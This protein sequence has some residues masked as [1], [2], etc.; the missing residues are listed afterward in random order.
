MLSIG[1]V[2]LRS[3]VLLAP[4]AGYCDLPFRLLCRE[5]GGIGLASTDLLNSRSILRGAPQAMRLAATCDED[6]PLCM[7]LYGNDTDP[8][9][10]A[11]AWAVDHGAR[12]IDINMGCPQDKVAK[13]NGGSLLLCDP[14]RTLVLADRIVDA[15]RGTGVPV[16]AKVRL[17]WCRQTM[18]APELARGLEQIG[19]SAVTV[20]GRTTD[21]KFKGVVD[22]DGIRAVVESV[23]SI[24][25]I[26]NGD[27]KTPQDARRMIDSTGCDGIMIARAALRTPW[28]FSRID[29]LLR[30][31]ICPPAP[32]HLEKLRI[33]RRHLELILRWS[34]ERTALHQFRQRISWYGKTMG[35][36]KG[37]KET[38]RTASS[39][40]EMFDVID[41]WIDRAGAVQAT[42]RIAETR[43]VSTM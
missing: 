38:I 10:E 34:D 21:Q 2:R 13:K 20:H 11:A 37:L 39:S 5:L 31:G 42:A 3:R 32:G 12:V 4:M 14:D 25:V 23:H 1:P 15:V 18:V 29:T 9:P 6:D 28:M 24:P 8:L 33:I 19:I 43:C 17:G 16:T 22:L 27:I 41:R 7:Q 30:T 26:G 35:H 40:G 36:V